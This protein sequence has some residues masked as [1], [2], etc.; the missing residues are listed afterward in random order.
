MKKLLLLFAIIVSQT[1]MAQNVGI[2]TTTPLA[3]LHVKDSSVLFSS[4]G[5]IP[6][7]PG[8]PP[9]AGAGRRMM[10]YADK[11]AFR[12]GYVAGP[13]WDK[14]SIGNYSFASGL[15]NQSK[16]STSTAMGYGN[17]ATGDFSTALGYGNSASGEASIVMGVNN[18]A[19]GLYS[20]ATG[21]QT[22][23]TGIVSTAMG[24]FT[25]A[26]GHSS[27]SMGIGTAATGDYSTALGASTIA[28]GAYSTSMGGFTAAKSAYETV[29]G[30]WNTDYTPASSI[31]WIAT[32]RLFTIG[33]GTSFSLKSDAMVVLK[34]GN[35]GIGTNNPTRPLSFPPF[36]EKKISLYPGASGDAGFG[37]F[38][39]ELRI[40]SDYAGADITFG[41]D[42]YTLGFT[43][44][45]RVKGNGNVGIGT[46][47]PLTRLHVT[48]SSVLFSAAFEA[49]VSP[50]LP[51]IQGYGRRMMWY[52]D[53]AAFRVGYV[54]DTQWDKDSIG[55]YSFAGGFSPKAKGQHSIALGFQATASADN[56][57]ALGT[58]TKASGIQSTALGIQSTAS[59]FA[60][61]AVGYNSIASGAYS[62]ALGYGTNAI[63]D[64]S[65]TFGVFTKAGGWYSTAMG[66]NTT[67]K[68]YASTVLGVF[69]DSILTTNETFISPSTP[70]FIVGNGDGNTARSNAITVLKNGNTGIGISTP[71]FPLSFAPVFG[72]KI[73]LL[74][75]SPNSYGFGIQSGLLQI[76]TDVSGA[77]I[78]FGYGSSNTFS[79]K[80]RI[81]GNGNIGIGLAAPGA[82]LSVSVDGT[83]LAGT[84]LGNT[85]RTNAGNLGNSPGSEISLAN[86]GFLSTS[87]SSLGIRAYRS[88]MGTDWT[89][90]ALLLEYDVDN[91]KRAPGPSSFFAISANG[92]FGFGTATPGFLLEVN[93]DAGKPGGGSWSAPSDA[94]MKENITPYADGLSTLLKINPVKYHYNQ[95]SGFDTKPEYI[96]VLAQDLK[97]IA[98]YMV[99]SFQKKGDTY[100]NVDNS[101]MTYILI[102]AVKE[103]QLMIDKQQQQIDE[104]K[105]LVQQLANK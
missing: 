19:S 20:T 93:G 91:T 60:S 30:S 45:M 72:D 27:T 65:T 34:N 66:G 67:A 10:W 11:S 15:N 98:P 25:T 79:E 89:T 92:G 105:K 58:N 64:V 82:K 14:D 100:Y 99:G 38:G 85:I 86:I 78:A 48:D 96:G 90:T 12:V 36:L 17:I 26:G 1:L 55:D 23:A 13:Q 68:G 28:S 6:A 16:G 69:N 35:T 21:N 3:R 42:D 74:S 2:G 61:F 57:I 53:K 29:I 37:V 95:L 71:A 4:I 7:T 83:E 40:N 56:S 46:N 73:S 44:R 32:D 103:Q 8:L 94:R 87:N 22:I 18:S 47:S 31:N 75:T 52:A 54:N 88:S 51:P 41:Y 49:S 97:S 70:L 81:K 24:Y 80:M 50:G 43:E 5:N 104:L 84:A 9:I 62:T 77:D 76:H 101:A 63:G 39:N 59:G 33:N 102:N